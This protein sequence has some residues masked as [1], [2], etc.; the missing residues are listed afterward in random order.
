MTSYVRTAAVVTFG[1]AAG[2]SWSLAVAEEAPFRGETTVNVIEVPVHV[3]DPETGAPVTGLPASDFQVFED[4]KPQT[5]S[6]FAELWRSEDDAA[7]DAGI[8]PDAAGEIYDDL[9]TRTVEMVYLVDLYLMN[10]EGR[11]RAADGLREV[12]SKGVPDGQNVSIVVYDGSLE[13]I[14]DRSDDRHE[15]LDG[16]ED[17]GFISPRGNQQTISLAGELIDTEVTGE[18]DQ[19]FYERRQR[20][21]EF[22]TDLEKKVRRVGDAAAATMSRYAAADG[23]RVLVV[24]TPGYPRTTW[25]PEY[26]TVD[27]VN[28]AAE[29]PVHDLWRGLAHEAADL[30]FTLYTVDASGIRVE[31]GSD[32]EIG[33]TDSL[34]DAFDKGSIFRIAGQPGFER[35]TGSDQTF[36]FDPGGETRNLGSWLEQT[37][38][39]MLILSSTSTGGEALFVR[40]VGPALEA[41]NDVLGHHYSVAYTADHADD[42]QTYSITVELPDH[43]DYRVVHRTGYVDQPAAVRSATRL[44]STMLFGGDANPLGVRVEAGNAEGRFRLGAAGS[45][46]VQIPIQLKIPYARLEMIQRG[47]LY[48]TKVWIT[49]FAEDEEGNQSA[50]T[51]HEQPITVA[52]EHYQEAVARGYFSYHTAVE[53]E[54]GEQ[55]VYIGIQEDLSGR[56]SIM[57]LE[58]DH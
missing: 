40:Q 30:G 44:R 32:V 21:R 19:A 36:A 25:V 16:L 34:E 58:F 48:W 15:I 14:V 28:A 51:S 7:E 55:R 27:Y 20:H 31:F 35:A 38:K 41:V 23:R 10:K 2:L 49:L 3:I 26:S 29:Y 18:R 57:P 45:K 43:P 37:R 13:T 46:R 5:I 33:I 22:I 52:A 4:G 8:G 9:R 42:G 53:I 1:I 24:F 56:T 11:N 12:Y 50:L 39:N 47:D 54:G 6:N 17:L